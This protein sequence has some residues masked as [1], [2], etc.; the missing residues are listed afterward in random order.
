MA[1]ILGMD[2]SPIRKD[3][4]EVGKPLPWPVYDSKR[5]LLLKDGFVI[6]TQSQLDILLVNGL[7][8]NPSWVKPTQA[9]KLGEKDE[10][11]K[12]DIVSFS[13]VNLQVGDV[14]QM[15]LS[16]G[17]DQRYA[18]RMI[19]YMEKKSLLVT[20][21][22]QNDSVILMRAGQSVVMRCF[23]GRNAYA[24]T[25]SV[26]RVC[27][28]PFPYLHLTYPI[29]VRGMKVRK[30]TRVKANVIGS[31]WREDDPSK[32]W[33]CTL[34]DISFSGAQI[35]CSSQLGALGDR[36]KIYL[37]VSSQGSTVYISPS[38]AIRRCAE[39]ESATGGKY[40]YGVEFHNL[41]QNES[42]ALQVLVYQNLFEVS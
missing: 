17:S 40:N 23:S 35:N 16:G 4:I 29:E 27:N 19:G 13:A 42:F 7:F 18:V 9:E 39:I 10:P 25:S 11:A 38:A 21:P 12:L 22:V 36:L 8:R 34:D 6:E 31:V 33:P 20:P 14:L 41:E 2:L 3:D 30:S 32:K 1:R 26:L 28:T 37:R 5:N 15:Q 24:F